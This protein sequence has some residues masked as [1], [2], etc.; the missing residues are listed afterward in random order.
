MTKILIIEDEEILLEI[1]RGKLEYE[2]YTVSVAKDG[3]V[4]L[5]KIK[6][7]KPDLVLLDLVMPKMDG[8]GVLSAKAKDEDI[9]NI[10]VIIIS[11]SGEPSELEKGVK[12]GAN[13][14]LI[15]AEFDPQEV[16]EKMRKYLSAEKFFIKGKSVET[17]KKESETFKKE[18]KPDSAVGIGKILVIEDE[19]FLR[20]LIV[21]KLSKD[22]FTVEFVV[23]GV[24]GIKKAEEFKPDLIF[25]DLILPGLH[26][27]DVLSQLKNNPNTNYIKVVILSN[28]GQREDVDK[29]V[30]LGA[31]DYM[32]KAHF[33]PDE[34]VEKAKKLLSR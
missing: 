11:N 21:Q 3:E 22:G 27:F 12:M 25:L 4:G 9:K 33:T 26:G 24:E 17:Y 32:V 13:D 8:F 30:A 29:G 10:P 6:E 2:G 34:I 15:K 5:A 18:E 28:L 20:E 31:T 16:I 7:E 19:K 23:D 1:L 14:Y